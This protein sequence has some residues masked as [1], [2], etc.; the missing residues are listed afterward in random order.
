MNISDTTGNNKTVVNFGN[1][2]VPNVYLPIITKD[3]YAAGY[4]DRFFVGRR[5]LAEMTETNQRD[6]NACDN[7]VYNKMDIKWKLTGPEYNVYSNGKVL[8]Y[9][10]VVNY[11]T[12]RIYDL[13]R[14]FPSASVILNNPRQFWRGF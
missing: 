7:R 9:T 12:L 5:N 4:I 1:V 8:E 11:N 3:S 13:R 2:Y 6:F 14:I 10:G